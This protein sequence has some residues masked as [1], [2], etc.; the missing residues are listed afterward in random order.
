M[1]VLALCGSL[2][3]RAGELTQV[4]V[5]CSLP[6]GQPHSDV[7]WRSQGCSRVLVAHLRKLDCRVNIAAVVSSTR[8]GSGSG[9]SSSRACIPGWP[10]G[11]SQPFTCAPLATRSRPWRVELSPNN[12]TSTDR[13]LP[14]QS[15]T[16]DGSSRGGHQFARPGELFG[17]KASTSTSPSSHQLADKP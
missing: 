4:E 3:S 15:G 6:C 13:C 7:P 5:W 9:G 16:F 14:C 17:A 11:A 1:G 2:V 12:G 10:A 8:S